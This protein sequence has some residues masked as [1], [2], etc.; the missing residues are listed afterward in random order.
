MGGSGV[1]TAAPVRFSFGLSANARPAADRTAE[2]NQVDLVVDELEL[3]RVPLRA[4]L[5]VRLAPVPY[6]EADASRAD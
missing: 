6:R 1:L 2:A 3:G 4:V 5:R